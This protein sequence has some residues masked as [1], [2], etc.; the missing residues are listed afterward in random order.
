MHFTRAVAGLPGLD[1]RNFE[2]AKCE[3]FV[4]KTVATDPMHSE[5]TRWLSGDLKPPE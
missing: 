5:A 2:C 1:L 3:V 4:T